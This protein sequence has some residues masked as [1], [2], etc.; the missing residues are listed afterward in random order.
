MIALDPDEAYLQDP[1]V[2][3]SFDISDDRAEKVQ[4]EGA[5]SVYSNFD[6][7][8]GPSLAHFRLY[9][10]PRARC[11]TISF[12]PVLR[13][14]VSPVLRPGVSGAETGARDPMACPI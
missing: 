10:A 5:D 12:A 7:V 13:P 8:L 14:G 2:E 11:N 1:A 4:E 3:F 9:T 6:I